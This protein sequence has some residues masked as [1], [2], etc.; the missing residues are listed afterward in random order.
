MKLLACF[1]FFP[2]LVFAQI[3]INIQKGGSAGANTV[4]NGPVIF[5][6]GNSLT[7]ASGASI[8]FSQAT[9]TFPSTV[10][11]T[12]GSYANPNWITSLAYSKLTGTPTTVAGLGVTNGATIDSWGTKTVPAG[13]VADLTSAQTFTNK[14]IGASQITGLATVATSGSYSDLINIPVLASLSALRSVSVSGLSTG[15]AVTTLGYYSAGDGGGGAYVY[16]ST[17]SVLDDGGSV[18]APNSGSGRWLAQFP[19]SVN[20]RQFGAKGDNSTNDCFSFYQAMSYCSANGRTFYTPAGNY[21]LP[22]YTRTFVVSSLPY[23]VTVGSPAYAVATAGSLTLVDGTNTLSGS[24]YTTSG[25]SITISTG[26]PHNVQV[27]DTIVLTAFPTLSFY[28]SFNWVGD[29]YGTYIVGSGHPYQTYNVDLG[30]QIQLLSKDT[31]TTYVPNATG[32]LYAGVYGVTFT[33]VTNLSVGDTMYAEMGVAPSDPS[34]AYVRWFAKITAISGNNVFF[35]NAVPE[36]IN[37][38]GTNASPSG[39]HKFYKLTQ[40]ARQITIRDLHLSMINFSIDRA[41]NVLI[42]NIHISSSVGFATVTRSYNTQIS[43]LFAEN[44][45]GVIASSIGLQGSMYGKFFY[46]WGNYNLRFEHIDIRA[47]KGVPFFTLESENRNVWGEDIHLGLDDVYGDSSQ[48]PVFQN[49]GQAIANLTYGSGTAAAYPLPP[50]LKDVYLVVLNNTNT[51]LLS[52]NGAGMS[53]TVVF[54]NLYVKGDSGSGITY[55]STPGGGSA[56]SSPPNV[57]LLASTIR[58]N[59]LWKNRLYNMRKPFRR[60]FPLP[61][62]GTPGL[63]LADMGVK[64]LLTHIRVFASTTTGLTSV[65]HANGSAGGSTYSPGTTFTGG[66]NF[67]AGQFTNDLQALTEMG[68]GTPNYFNDGQNFSYTY[69]S[70]FAAGNYIVVEGEVLVS[71]LDAETKPDLIAGSGAPTASAAFVNQEYIDT[72]NGAKYWA[73]SAGNGSSDWVIY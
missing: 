42:D 15:A 62:S 11:Q 29:G 37:G 61:T 57:A 3:P 48:I 65:G 5:G 16:S 66:D 72:A 24:D 31:G 58:G 53:P 26:G 23:T 70:N 35:D 45:Y 32:Y 73:K 6:S 14:S 7:I 52:S 63:V 28:G 20:A 46:G 34:Q 19:N 2:G 69:S 13:T 12:S 1:L 33:S 43:H 71:S 59:L 49:T 50:N 18:I 51:H 55:P 25:N 67:V 36:D 64:G 30:V 56:Y 21:L 38:Y 10:V 4:S 60:I 54:E 9:V 8:D 41:E 68:P 39:I 47:L 27:G 40:A 44:I 22:V 17:S